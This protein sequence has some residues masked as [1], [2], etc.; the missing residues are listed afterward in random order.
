[1]NII[2]LALILNTTDCLDEIQQLGLKYPIEISF[3]QYTYIVDFEEFMTVSGKAYLQRGKG[4]IVNYAAP[5][6]Q[7]VIVSNDAVWIEQPLLKQVMKYG[8]IQDPL[9]YILF[10][11]NSDTTIN[12]QPSECSSLKLPDSFP[13]MQ[14]P[15]S[16][17]YFPS[18]FDA[19]IY[20]GNL[21]KTLWGLW[22]IQENQNPV[23]L[24]FESIKKIK[25]LPEK[26]IPYK[27][28]KNF[29]LIE[30]F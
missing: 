5:D 24:K 26:W 14:L 10:N 30:L 4:L 18:S 27:S 13:A 22:I 9:L 8:N 25:S 17:C 28:P 29:E 3:T 20:T 19:K 7:I 12:A 21:N 16:C 1:M 15:T 6:S 2:L 11:A 23:A